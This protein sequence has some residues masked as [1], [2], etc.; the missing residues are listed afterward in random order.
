M[1]WVNSKKN[2]TDFIGHVLIFALSCC[3]KN[4]EFTH[5]NNMR[6]SIMPHYLWEYFINYTTL[7][8]WVFY[9]SYHLISVSIL[10]IILHHPCEYFI[11]HTTLLVWVFYPLYHAICVSFFNQL[12]PTICVSIL[13]FMPR[14]LRKYF[15]N[16]PFWLSDGCALRCVMLKIG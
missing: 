8:V 6:V 11:N 4:R 2:L 9:Q 1:L 16:M 14:Y 13:Q 12:Y 7:S 10:S 15:W 3:L 5:H